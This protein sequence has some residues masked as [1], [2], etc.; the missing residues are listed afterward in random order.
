MPDTGAGDSGGGTGEDN[1]DGGPGKDF[2]NGGSDTD[3]DHAT[4][5]QRRVLLP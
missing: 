5:C 2:C 3:F 1:L 4:R